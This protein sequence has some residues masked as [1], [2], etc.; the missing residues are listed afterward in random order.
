MNSFYNPVFLSKILKN[1]LF[2]IDRQR[3]LNDEELH[4]YQN[5]N[6]KKMVRFANTVPLYH[7]TYKKAGVHPDDIKS[8]RDI[9]KL[10]T[11]SKHD[12]KKYYPD[13]LVS[14][15]V[16]K[17]KLIEI[18]TSGTTGKSLSLYVD[19]VEIVNGLFGYIRFLREHDLSWRKKRLSIIGDFAPHTAESGYIFKG[20]QS[21]G[22]S[23]L[24]L[25][26]IQWLNTNDPPEKVIEEIN[27]FKPDFIGGYTGM[28][29]HIAL[30]K[31]KGF[32]KDISP[33]I[34]ASTGSVLNSSLKKLIEQTFHAS[35]FESYGS[36]E[37][38]PIAF[39]CK[40]G[41]YHV[42]SDYVHLEFLKDGEP[43]LSREAGK[44]VVT[45]LFGNGT[46]IIRY[47]A[48]NDIVAPLYEKCQCGLSG[49]LLDRIYGREDI[50]LYSLDGKV[51]LPS[52]FG[53]IF[54]RILYELKTNKLKD[55]RV[56]QYSLTSVEINIVIDE[57]LRTVGPS[58]EALSSFLIKNFKEK[59]GSQ[60]DI[61]IKE[62]DTIDREKPRIISM[63][64]K[65][66]LT[67]TGYA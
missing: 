46:P 55:V 42:M 58:V 21:Q 37:T 28:L 30:L 10:P 31:E 7:D 57:K 67:I 16:K 43:V 32:G 11:V 19:M 65:T 63:V 64:D 50:A 52:S 45:K 12:F 56:T 62:V 51:L 27:T 53:E 15:K 25:K 1:Y 6:L 44:V 24:F 8:I 39:Q 60:V 5:K 13:G 33:K 18:T 34:I 26:N 35:V 41:K 66:K 2:N 17:S 14:S 22:A 40:Y 48:M 38:G 36:T 3:R 61:Q 47:D 29:G 54:S 4:S 23:N 49:M 20:I 59:L 9:T